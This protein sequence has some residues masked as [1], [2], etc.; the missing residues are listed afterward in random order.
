MDNTTE[1]RKAIEEN[2]LNPLISSGLIISY[3]RTENALKGLKYIINRGH[4]GKVDRK[5][6]L[7]SAK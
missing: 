4:K 1:L 7:E 5:Q 2:A 6:Q 3:E